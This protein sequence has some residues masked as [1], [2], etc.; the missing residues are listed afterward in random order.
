MHT[1]AQALLMIKPVSFPAFISFD[2]GSATAVIGSTYAASDGV[3]FDTP[4][5]FSTNSD[6][7]TPSIPSPQGSVF[8]RHST[9]LAFDRGFS[10]TA[11]RNCRRVRYFY[12]S[13]GGTL[14]L[15]LTSNLYT[16]TYSIVASQ[17][18][19]FVHDH[20]LDVLKASDANWNFGYLTKVDFLGTD[21]LFN[22]DKLE[23]LTG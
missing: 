2:E 16:R 7:F 8:A 19:W 1:I 17:G 20:N 22:M 21:E 4:W 5:T 12:R 3:T 10:I 13:A 9:G 18:G 23:I 14:N 11:A 15:R 6:F